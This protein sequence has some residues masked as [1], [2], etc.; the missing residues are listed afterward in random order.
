[1]RRLFFALL[2][3]ITGVTAASQPPEKTKD[4]PSGLKPGSDLPASIYPYNVTGPEKSKGKFHNLV[5]EYGLE[6]TVMIVAQGLDYGTT[7]LIDLLKSLDTA[8]EKNP[9]VRLHA[10]AVF[11]TDELPNVVTDDDKREDLAPRVEDMA[12][13]AMLK[14]VVLALDSKADLE[15][16]DLSKTSAVTVI[17]YNKLKVVSVHVLPKDKLTEPAVKEI[18]GEVAAKL[19]ASRK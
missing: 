3:L 9:N 10:F 5:A 1:M 17:L 13:K 18:M 4:A 12:K 11:L 8:I 19:G 14:H 2:V 15:K 16:F 7:P 6:P